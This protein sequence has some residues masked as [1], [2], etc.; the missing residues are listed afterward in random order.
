MLRYPL[1]A[2]PVR[3]SV[4]VPLG[5]A[6][7][8]DITDAEAVLRIP[9]GGTAYDAPLTLETSADPAEPDGEGQAGGQARNARRT[10]IDSRP[11]TQARGGAERAIVM[12]QK[13]PPRFSAPR[14]R[15]NAAHP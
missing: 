9:L 15:K 12:Y 13:P 11:R 6:V 7:Q 3:T 10:S 2:R 14:T 4:W 1:A 8:S 5:Q